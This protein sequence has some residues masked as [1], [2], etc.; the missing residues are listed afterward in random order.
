[1]LDEMKV[2]AQIVFAVVIGYI[3]GKM[4]V[5]LRGKN[6]RNS[7]RGLIFAMDLIVIALALMVRAV[8]S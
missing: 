4:F 1:M 6:W 5:A 2:V 7:I 3:A 8:R